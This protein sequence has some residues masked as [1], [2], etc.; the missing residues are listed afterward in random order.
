MGYTTEF[1]GSFKITPTLKQED[2][3]YLNKFSQSRRRGRKGLGEEFGVEGEFF[4]D[5]SEEFGQGKDSNIIDYS[6]PPKTQ[7]GLWCNWEPNE[8]GTEL[9]W[10]GAE[11]FY[12]YIEWLNYLIDKILKPRGYTLDGEVTWQGEEDSDKGKM[13]VKKNKVSTKSGHTVYR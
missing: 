5:G 2:I 4:V 9:K 6:V 10:N 12:N 11:K 8:N 7:P 3:I 1:E 13:I